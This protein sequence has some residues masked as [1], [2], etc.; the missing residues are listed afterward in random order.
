MLSQDCSTRPTCALPLLIRLEAAVCDVNSV[1]S[2][3]KRSGILENR[4]RAERKLG[5]QS[6]VERDF[7]LMEFTPFE[8]ETE[9][10]CF[11]KRE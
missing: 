11:T 7:F 10:I 3:D 4:R 2:W 8:F 9:K 5:F 6:A 1:D